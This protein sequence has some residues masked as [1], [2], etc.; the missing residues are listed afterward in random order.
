MTC[1]GNNLPNN[2]SGLE[3]LKAFE[4]K[5]DAL[6]AGFA[7]LNLPARVVLAGLHYQV[8]AGFLQGVPGLGET[9]IQRIGHA[10]PLV[11]GLAAKPFDPN[12]ATAIPDFTAAHFHGS[13]QAEF[14]TYLH[15]SDVMPEV[16]R[17]YFDVEVLDAS[18]FRLSHPSTD[19]ADAEARDVTLSEIALPFALE[20]DRKLDPEFAR[21]AKELPAIDWPYV[22]R[23]IAENARK[24]R[25]EMAEADVITDAS[26]RHMFGFD[27]RTFLFIRSVILA[28]AEFCAKLATMTH[29]LVLSGQMTEDRMDYAFEFSSLFCDADYL[30]GLFAAGA[31]A[32]KEEV[33]RFIDLYSIDFRQTPAQD[34]GGDGFFPPFARF[35]EG[36][37]FSP[38]LAMAFLQV[39]NAV[40]A[41]A[42][43]DKT[44][45][46]NEVSKELEPVLLHQARELLHRGGD[47]IAIEDIKFHG[48]Q[49]DLLVTAPGEDAV[50]L[51]QA[52]GTL[53][54][55]GARLTDR[56]ST[57]VREGIRQI[58]KFEALTEER[59]RSA[60]EAAL[61]RKIGTLDV[62]HAVMVRSCFGEA[63]V[64]APEFPYIRITAPLLALALE[65][66]R[67]SGLPTSIAALTQAI[68]ETEARIYEEAGPY[69]E[70]GE[71]TLA[72]TTIRMPLLKWQPGSLDTLRRQWWDAAIRPINEKP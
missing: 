61:E 19:F 37:V 24:Y 25:H 65:H 6:V 54:P 58:E 32:Q 8:F 44:T 68:A 15:F 63:E 7:M 20:K 50:L 72:G 23:F 59:Q 13:D 69:W 3:A 14:M 10:L 46:N 67:D 55:Q 22:S 1:R 17:G 33:E 52:K 21:M 34:W 29:A 31:G 71:I 45:F 64:F 35:D 53:P 66:H 57:R 60:I 4:A 11:R 70:E 16:R 42:K 39:R 27:R 2:E 51:I 36:L 18:T 47:W 5:A 30:F 26:I 41:F 43:K 40:F 48:G 38:V 62:H 28:F 9:M 56:L 49:V 12:A